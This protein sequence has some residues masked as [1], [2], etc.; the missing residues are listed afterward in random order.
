MPCDF[1]EAKD[2]SQVSHPS[3]IAMVL[4]LCVAT[5]S[6]PRVGYG[7]NRVCSLSGIISWK[8]STT[9]APDGV[10]GLIYEQVPLGQQFIGR[11]D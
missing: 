11:V 6:L 9:C 7:F 2:L 5:M 3:E 10:I 1:Q 8:L 4:F